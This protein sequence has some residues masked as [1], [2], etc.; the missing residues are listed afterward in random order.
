MAASL[1]YREAMTTRATV[2]AQPTHAQRQAC[3]I[4]TS[5]KRVLA[6]DRRVADVLQC[7]VGFTVSNLCLIAG[8]ML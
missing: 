5:R 8:I 7:Q 1:V 3:S 2:L 4:E 6:W